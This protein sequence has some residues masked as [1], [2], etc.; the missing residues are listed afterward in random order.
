MAVGR[1][2]RLALASIPSNFVFKALVNEVSCVTAKFKTPLSSIL[3]P[4]PAITPPLRLVVADGI[5]AVTNTPLIRL[6]EIALGKLAVAK[7][8]SITLAEIVAGKLD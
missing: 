5:F 8:P 6:A 4:V 2:Y 1:E 3:R 7:T